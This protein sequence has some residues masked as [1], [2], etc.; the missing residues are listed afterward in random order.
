MITATIGELL[1]GKLDKMD[2]GGHYLYLVRDGETIL[3][4]GKSRDVIERL[5]G[6]LGDGGWV[7]YGP[8]QLGEMIRVNLPQSRGW[9]VVLLTPADCG[10]GDIDDAEEELIAHYNP[11][12]NVML[13][14]HSSGD[15]PTQYKTPWA[16]V[17][18]EGV[19]LE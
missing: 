6:H 14:R 12:L 4:V 3:Y 9:E 16:K 2:T 10:A 18:N 13:K 19:R 1:S 17:A 11:H 15:L 7:F 8:S 5:R